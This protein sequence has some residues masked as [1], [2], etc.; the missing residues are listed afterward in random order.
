MEH[1]QSNDVSFKH[2]ARNNNICSPTPQHA[3]AIGSL[4]IPNHAQ[5]TG[6]HSPGAECE[7]LSAV[8]AS[9]SQSQI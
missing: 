7:E 5:C 4:K 9:T 3:K 6:P 8:A 1:S 2:I